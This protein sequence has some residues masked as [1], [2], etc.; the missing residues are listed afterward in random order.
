DELDLAVRC[1]PR[2][3]DLLVGALEAILF[4]RLVAREVHPEHDQAMEEDRP[5]SIAERAVRG[6]G[7]AILAQIE[8]LLV[9]RPLDGLDFVLEVILEPEILYPAIE[10]VLDRGPEHAGRHLAERVADGHVVEPPLDRGQI[11][12]PEAGHRRVAEI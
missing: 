2:R 7:E 1:P 5:V 8:P 10:I 4:A 3:P 6:F 12:V 9:R 11:A